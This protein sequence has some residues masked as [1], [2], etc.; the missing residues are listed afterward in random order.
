MLTFLLDA[1]YIISLAGSTT[2]DS[3]GPILLRI[4]NLYWSLQTVAPYAEFD[5]WALIV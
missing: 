4:Y 1:V 3:G 5:T 2:I